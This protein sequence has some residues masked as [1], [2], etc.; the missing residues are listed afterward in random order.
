LLVSEWW[1]PHV[2]APRSPAAFTGK[3]RLNSRMPHVTNV[4][5]SPR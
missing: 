3:R 5:T 4:L 1:E 2:C